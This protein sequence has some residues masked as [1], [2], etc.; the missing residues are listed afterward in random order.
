[1]FAHGPPIAGRYRGS[2]QITT[3]E[4]FYGPAERTNKNKSEYRKNKT[5]NGGTTRVATN[6]RLYLNPIIP[7]CDP[8]GS[9]NNNGHRSHQNK[10]ISANDCHA[11]RKSCWLESEATR[12]F[13]A[14]F[15]QFNTGTKDFNRCSRPSASELIATIQ[16]KN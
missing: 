10:W 15:K 1:M 6:L 5:N 8:K 14:Q 16:K 7:E 9:G 2:R 12:R 4:D 3:L 13:R 11:C